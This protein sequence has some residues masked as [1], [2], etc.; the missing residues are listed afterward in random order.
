MNIHI[1]HLTGRS[2]A[3]AAIKH[4]NAEMRAF[5]DALDGADITVTDWEANFIEG[6]MDLVTFT[7][8]QPKVIHNMIDSY[9]HKIKW[10]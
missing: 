6:C 9:G 8:K 4:S 1:S 10:R 5:L 2:T 7:G 3:R